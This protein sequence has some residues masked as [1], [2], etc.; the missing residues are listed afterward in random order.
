MN[1]VYLNIYK[2]YDVWKI[3]KYF[4]TFKIFVLLGEI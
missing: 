1:L 2:S 3:I 4:V